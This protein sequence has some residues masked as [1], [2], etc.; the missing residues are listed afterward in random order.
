MCNFRP[1]ALGLRLQ[2][3][4]ARLAV[5]TTD[6]I[7]TYCPPSPRKYT[8]HNECFYTRRTACLSYETVSDQS[9]ILTGFFDRF[10]RD[11][12][13]M[14]PCS[15][16]GCS[17]VIYCSLFTARMHAPPSSLAAVAPSPHCQHYMLD[18]YQSCQLFFF[19]LRHLMSS[20]LHMLTNSFFAI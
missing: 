17:V 18:K 2:T 20:P 12:N 6:V 9:T 10:W 16:C 4:P 19:L 11:G 5:F 15:A 3:T 8:I 13:S 14:F 1:L 7:A